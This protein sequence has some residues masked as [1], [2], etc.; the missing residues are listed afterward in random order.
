MSSA[1]TVRLT[2]EA[3]ALLEKL[4]ASL[5]LEHGVKPPLYAIVEAALRLAWRR[6]SELLAEL[7]GWRPLSREEA[8]RLL[9][10]HVVDIG[11]TDAARD[12][13]EVIYGGGGGVVGAGGYER[14]SGGVEREG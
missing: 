9:E 7:E 13:D 6:R 3:R 8:E 1:G 14:H 4:Q 12:H 10:E 5:V 11:E 2:R